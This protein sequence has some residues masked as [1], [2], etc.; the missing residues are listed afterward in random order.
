M[1]QETDG[2]RLRMLNH[3][4][5]CRLVEIQGGREKEV[6]FGLIPPESRSNLHCHTGLAH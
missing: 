6:W 1:K 4:L 2:D 3:R 5:S